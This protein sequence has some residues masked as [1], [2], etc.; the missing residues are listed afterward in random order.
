MRKYIITLRIL[1]YAPC[2]EIEIEMALLPSKRSDKCYFSSLY[3]VSSESSDDCFIG[4]IVRS[5]NNTP[6]HHRFELDVSEVIGNFAMK[7]HCIN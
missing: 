5:R 4:I 3:R 1:L 2:I 6:C 7:T